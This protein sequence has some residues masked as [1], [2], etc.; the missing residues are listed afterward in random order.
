MQQMN[1]WEK[2]TKAAPFKTFIEDKTPAV[3]Q[4]ALLP[5][6]GEALLERASVK[7][8]LPDTAAPK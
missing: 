3:F 4:L 2:A 5:R 6:V 7:D 1:S 8:D